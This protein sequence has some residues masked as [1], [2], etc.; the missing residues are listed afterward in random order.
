MRLCVCLQV[1]HSQMRV[2]TGLRDA[3]ILQLLDQSKAKS[4][5]RKSFYH[6]P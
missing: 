6:G 3:F 1:S 5:P 2:P 4:L